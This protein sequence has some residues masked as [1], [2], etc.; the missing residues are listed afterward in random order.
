MPNLS[1][2]LAKQP[3]PDA[4]NS[5]LNSTP[6]ATFDDFR[7]AIINARFKLSR[8]LS[9]VA[10][11]VL[12]HPNDSAL[13]SV[14]KLAEMA[15]VSPST[16]IRLAQAM[17]YQGFSDMQKVLR[18]PLVNAAPSHSE[19]IRHLRGEQVL[20][21]TNDSASVLREFTKANLV[22]LEYLRDNA[23]NIP[24]E[25]A[26]ELLMQADRIHVLGLRRS[27]PIAAYL[28]YALNRIGCR[29]YLM[30]GM[31]DSLAE[32]SRATGPND[33]L[34]A[35]SFPPYAESTIQTCHQAHARGLKIL[36]LTDSLL[37][38]MAKNAAVTLE[39]N[40]AELLGFRSLTASMDMAQSLVIGT[41]FKLRGKALEKGQTTDPLNDLASRIN[42]SDINC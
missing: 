15:G 39:I 8:R 1:H 38:P 16:F 29:A 26:S 19:R 3:P 4:A 5:N 30:D 17:G 11:F 32:Q 34:L 42:L 37:S 27:F 25:A 36:A 2:T 24:L 18:E 41:A 7:S 6:P 23:A 28:S 35:I 12:Q 31:G 13:H 14:T 21:D 10:R 20:N 33:L 9:E 22:S 40:D